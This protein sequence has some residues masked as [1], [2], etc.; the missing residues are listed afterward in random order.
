MQLAPLVLYVGDGVD[1]T[2]FLGHVT[3]WPF[4]FRGLPHWSIARGNLLALLVW[5]VG[6]S[7]PNDRKLA[8]PQAG[9]SFTDEPVCGGEHW[10]L[11][12]F[13]I[14]LFKI[15]FERHDCDCTGEDVYALSCLLK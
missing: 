13:C 4:T 2:V 14:R 10:H 8:Q 12:T 1:F 3:P 11:S 5:L 6:H 7:C 15:I 9:E